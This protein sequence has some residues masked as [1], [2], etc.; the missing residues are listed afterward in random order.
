MKVYLLRALDE[1]DAVNMRRAIFKHKEVTVKRRK[2]SKESDKE[3]E[4]ES[5]PVIPLDTESNWWDNVA[6]LWTPSDV[7]QN[8]LVSVL[9]FFFQEKNQKKKKPKLGRAELPP[10]DENLIAESGSACKESSDVSDRAD[11]SADQLLCAD[12]HSSAHCEC[13]HHSPTYAVWRLPQ[14]D[15]G[16]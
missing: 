13:S 15:R 5:L 9:R 8:N 10:E 11:V 3:S 12:L 14:R 16:G 1:A 4:P 7:Q 6:Q 2:T